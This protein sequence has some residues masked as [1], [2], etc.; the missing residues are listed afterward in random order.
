MQEHEVSNSQ[1]DDV[2]AAPALAGEETLD[3]FEA[4]LDS[5]AGALEAL[6]ADDLDAAEALVAGLD[7]VEPSSDVPTDP[8]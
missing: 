2:P 4:D 1:S 8:V 7:T 3:G 6:D 5:V